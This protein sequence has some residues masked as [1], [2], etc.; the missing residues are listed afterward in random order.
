MMLIAINVRAIII[1]VDNTLY[2]L[3]YIC[4]GPQNYYNT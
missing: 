3:S 2:I 1:I 4:S